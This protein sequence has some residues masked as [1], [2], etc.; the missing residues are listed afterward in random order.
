MS[1]FAAEWLAL[2]E[3]FDLR[4]RNPHVLDAVCALLGSRPSVRIS[5]FACGAGSTVRALHSRVAARQHWNLIDNDPRLLTI[6]RNAVL[7]GSSELDAIQLDLSNDLEA[8]F[9]IPADLITMSALLDLVSEAWLQELLRNVVARALPVYAALI[10]D[11]RIDL[12]PADPADDAVISAFNAHQGTDKGF[13]AALGPAAA[14]A[15]IAGFESS[16]YKVVSGNSDWVIGTDHR[17]MQVELFEGWTRAAREMRTL[18]DAEVA[19]WLGRRTKLVSDGLSST[20]VG[21]VDLLALPS[22]TR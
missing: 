10:Y 8:A 1:G 12:S 20:R 15:A 2:R 9:N 4:A 14:T 13:G 6:A 7:G 22:A 16:G 17:T 11:G 21:H 3:P 19:G 18:E 5:D